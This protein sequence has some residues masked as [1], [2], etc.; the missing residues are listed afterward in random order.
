MKECTI[1]R[2]GQIEEFKPNKLY[3]SIYSACLSA[4]I[5]DKQAKETADQITKYITKLINSSKIC[6]TSDQIF[7]IVTKQLEE[8][9]NDI[10]FM[11]ETH[12]D[13]S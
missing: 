11:Y 13:I 9:N 8:Y 4:H 5:K 2:K 6:I 1:K 10:A 7:K 12:R 3:K